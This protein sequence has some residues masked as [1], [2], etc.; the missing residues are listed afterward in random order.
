[1]HTEKAFGKKLEK[2]NTDEVFNTLTHLVGTVLVIIGGAFLIMNAAMQKDVWKIVS[3]GIYIAFIML[4]FLFSTIYHGVK[5]GEKH[6]RN[7]RTMDYIGVFLAISGSFIP[8][9]LVLLR[10]VFGWTI[11]GIVLFL[12]LTGIFLRVFARVS[13]YITGTFQTV[14]GLISIIIAPTLYR[15]SPVAL[16]LLILGGIFYILGF[17]ILAIR[18][19][20]LIKGKFGF[21]E[22]WHIFVLLGALSHFLLIWFYVL[23]Y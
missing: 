17:I 16:Y 8:L 10:G 14:I 3:F 21:H 12:T 5:K 11:L 1:M 22:I 4:M 23:Y 20:N 18:K 7:L 6:E 19:P 9:C 2:S 15:I 13:V